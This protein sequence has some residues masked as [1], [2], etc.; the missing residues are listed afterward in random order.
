[1]IKPLL[2]ISYVKRNEESGPVAGG[3]KCRISDKGRWVV[4]PLVLTARTAVI[5]KL[6]WVMLAAATE[7]A[8]CT[9]QPLTSHRNIAR[10]SQLRYLDDNI[11]RDYKFVPE[12][13][14]VTV[15]EH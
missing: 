13:G 12:G 8:A 4:P 6:S 2:G 15:H 10:D 9:A 3:L 7:S 5:H 14:I 1:M 11:S